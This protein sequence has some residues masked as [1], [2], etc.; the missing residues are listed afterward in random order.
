MRDLDHVYRTFGYHHNS[1]KNLVM[2]GILG[3]TQMLQMLKALREAPP[4][5]IGGR[6][7][8]ACEDLQSEESRL[9]PVKG[10]T[11]KANRNVLVFHL[12]GNAKVTLRPSGTE[13]KAKA[14]VELAGAPAPNGLVGEL[15][16]KQCQQI[17]TEAESLATAFVADAFGRIGLKPPA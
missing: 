4:T 10:E 3:K 6:A 5:T 8:R 11:D 9:G 12:E 14:Y 2:T 7:V 17:D 16:Q 13:P 15:W 1:V